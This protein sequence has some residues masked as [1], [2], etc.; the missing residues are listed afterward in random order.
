MHLENPPFG[1]NMKEFS[2]SKRYGTAAAIP[3][4]PTNEHKAPFGNS[5]MLARTLNV[6]SVWNTTKAELEGTHTSEGT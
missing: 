5:Y 1:R 3:M 6:A 4:V 2:N